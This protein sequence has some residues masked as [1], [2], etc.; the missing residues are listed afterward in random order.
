MLIMSD[1]TTQEYC[2]V[3]RYRTIRRVDEIKKYKRFC[4]CCFTSLKD[5]YSQIKTGRLTVVGEAF[6]A[7]T[8]LSIAGK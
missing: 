4:I 5:K 8:Q 7:A 2:S 1:P 6:V 3:Y